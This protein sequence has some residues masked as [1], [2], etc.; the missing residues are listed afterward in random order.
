MITAIDTN[1]LI[2]ILGQEPQSVDYARAA[3]AQ[4]RFG[5]SLLICDVVYAELASRFESRAQLDEFLALSSIG[6]DPCNADTL[7]LAGSTWVS[8]ARNRQPGL[9]CAQC[10]SQTLARCSNC[11][12]VLTSRQR[13]LADFY[14]GSHALS[15]ADRLLTRDR[16]YYVMY[17]PDLRLF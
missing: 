1:I 11:D 12:A 6:L 3:L 2:A 9:A 8:Y 10:G 7:F 5:D 17:F 13:V 16:G 14:V 4:A 15:Q